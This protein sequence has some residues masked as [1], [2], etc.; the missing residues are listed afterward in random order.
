MKKVEKQLEEHRN[1]FLL[2]VR[3]A[4]KRN[5]VVMM[6]L[7]NA[8]EDEYLAMSNGYGIEF[9]EVLKSFCE[10]PFIGRVSPQDAF[11]RWNEYYDDVALV[12]IYGFELED[13]QVQISI[14]DY[15][16]MPSEGTEQ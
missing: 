5:Q 4:V 10:M 15:Y 1:D 12:E 3:A 8:E 11:D 16:I 14:L 7:Y 9:D 13:G 2:D 6:I